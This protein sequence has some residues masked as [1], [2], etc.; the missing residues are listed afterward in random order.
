MKYRHQESTTMVWW[1]LLMR[2]NPYVAAYIRWFHLFVQIDK[3]VMKL[4]IYYAT[5]GEAISQFDLV[6]I[7]L[8]SIRI[9]LLWEVNRNGTGEM[10][11]GGVSR[12][13]GQLRR[14][15]LDISKNWFK[16]MKKASS[17]FSVNSFRTQQDHHWMVLAS[18]PSS[19]DAYTVLKTSN[20]QARV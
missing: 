14:K 8:L 13:F 4:L 11:H 19:S 16:M 9:K 17:F 15:S 1:I 18:S 6:L 10:L 2:L 7:I 5:L 20:F 12:N 3:L